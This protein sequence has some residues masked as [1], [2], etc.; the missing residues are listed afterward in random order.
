MIQEYV[1][2]QQSDVILSKEIDGNVFYKS[3]CDCGPHKKA[4]RRVK[5]SDFGS[6]VLGDPSKLYYHDIQL[7]GLEAPEVSL[8]AGWYQ[9]ADIWDLGVVVSYPGSKQDCRY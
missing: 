2:G 1:L 4:V 9:S 5:L 6:A 3:Q 8:K 7:E